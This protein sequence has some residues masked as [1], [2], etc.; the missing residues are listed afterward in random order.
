MRLQQKTVTVL[1]NRT[2]NMKLE[3]VSYSLDIP[4]FLWTLLHN[5]SPVIIIVLIYHSSCKACLSLLIFNYSAE[6]SCGSSMLGQPATRAR[7]SF[8]FFIAE[9]L[10]KNASNTP[11]LKKCLPSSWFHWNSLVFLKL[12]WSSCKLP[13]VSHIHFSL[14]Y[15]FLDFH[16]SRIAIVFVLR[17]QNCFL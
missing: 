15:P 1:T 13:P 5:I 16:Q 2:I 12:E 10:T 3:P 11:P 6:K 8:L 4:L 9:H 17:L 7:F 14:W